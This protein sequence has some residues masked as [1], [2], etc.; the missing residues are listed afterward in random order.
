MSPFD[1]PWPEPEIP[2][3]RAG[4]HGPW[5]ISRYPAIK[6]VPGYFLPAAAQAAGWVIKKNGKNVWMSITRLEIESHMPHIAAARGHVVIT[7]LGMGFA[8]YNIAKRPEVTKVTVVEQS[9]EIAALL[10]NST[11]W[12]SWPGAGK[13]TVVFDDALNYKPRRE[14]DFLYADIWPKV[15]DILAL[16]QTQ[17]M[18]RNINAKSVG[19]W[20]QEYDYVTWSKNNWHGGPSQAGYRSFVKDIGL[21]LIEQNNYRYPYLAYAAVTLQI[22]ASEPRGR[23]KD[24]LLLAYQ[25]YLLNQPDLID[26][27]IRAV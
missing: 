19:F 20:T 12:K 2:A 14:V 27:A 17:Q 24:R 15:G 3:Y 5:S 26:Q 9:K 16:K 4:S 1:L 10:D 22:A 21:P 6:H 8:L 25:H 11:Q 23:G 7:G 18:Q 13:V